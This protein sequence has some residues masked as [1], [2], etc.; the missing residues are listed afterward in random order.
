MKLKKFST[1]IG[2]A[3]AL[4]GIG[5]SANAT[6]ISGS[7]TTGAGSFIKLAPGFTDSSP[8]N[9]VGN[10]TF[11][12]LNLYAFDEDQ[13]TTV[14]TSA[15]NA[16]ILAST[17]VAG[18]LAVGTVVAS[19]YVFFDPA[20][21]SHQVG[22]VTFDSVILA[23]ITSTANLLASDYLANTGVNYLNPALRGL[24]AGDS[25]TISITDPKIINID[26]VASSPG[27]YVRILTAFSPGGTG[28]PVPEPASFA[29]LSIG[30][31]G[32][33]AARHRKQRV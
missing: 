3:V 31:A 17:G 28:N 1:V 30:L 29:L 19:H 18:A 2:L 27:D 5:T 12:N 26:W 9:T 16:D 15:L 8:D 11:Q 25:V 4:V 20:G 23:I 33:A 7:V 21:T 14:Q 6:V 32:L 13:N 24:E 22:T 10:D